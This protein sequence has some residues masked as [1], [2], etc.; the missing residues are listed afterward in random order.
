MSPLT[1]IGAVTAGSVRDAIVNW[2]HD[3]AT[4][5]E[6]KEGL[7]HFLPELLKGHE[8]NWQFVN[9]LQHDID[10]QFDHMYTAEFYHMLLGHDPDGVSKGGE[11]PHRE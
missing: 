5:M 11:E 2:W 1:G 6:I 3:G 9:C 8:L 7:S 10:C 4:V